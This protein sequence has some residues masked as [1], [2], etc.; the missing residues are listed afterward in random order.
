M[1]GVV[2][3]DFFVYGDNIPWNPANYGAGKA[4][5]IQFTKYGASALAARSI[6]VNSITPG[7]F[8][9]VTP[10]FDQ[11]FLERLS[12]KAMMKR[13]DEAEELDGALLLLASDASSFM[14]G[15]N[16]IFDGSAT[17]W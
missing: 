1:Y 6:L 3:P 15:Q 5:V 13:V 2:A 8:P 14:T 16:I 9:K 7:C 11:G 4:G 17:A 12:N 10:G